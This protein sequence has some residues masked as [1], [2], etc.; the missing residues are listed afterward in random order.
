MSNN[1][2]NIISQ[3]KQDIINQIINIII[4]NQL[5]INGAE[6]I[7]TNTMKHLKKLKIVL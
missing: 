1:N 2:E 5:S 7:L 4:E 6:E 3:N